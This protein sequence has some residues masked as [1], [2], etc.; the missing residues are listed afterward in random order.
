MR[1]CLTMLL[2]AV[3]ASVALGQNPEKAFGVVGRGLNQQPAFM[4]RLSVDRKDLTYT[5]GE[6]LVVTV[7]S[8][9][10]G[11]L[12][13][14]YIQVEN[15]KEQIYVLYPNEFDAGKEIPAK[16][17][18]AIPTAKDSWDLKCIPPFG[19]GR[20]F[21]LVS[22][23]PLKAAK[24]IAAKDGPAVVLQ[25][26]VLGLAREAQ[27][28][29]PQEFA[30]VYLD[31]T[32]LAARNADQ[33][34][35]NNKPR[36]VAVCI[37][38]SDYADERINDLTISH[39]DAEVMAQMLKDHCR[40]E[41]IVLLTNE[42]AT[43]SAIEAAIFKD[44][45]SKT[46]PG[47]TVFIFYSGHGGR[48][49]DT[50]G[51]EEDGFDEYL[52]PQDGK[53]GADETMILDDVFGRWMQQLEGRKVCIILDNCHSG[54]AAKGLKKGKFPKG[55]GLPAVEKQVEKT[56]RVDFFD[57]ELRR[58]KDLGQKDT[59]VV[60]ACQANQ[61]AWE[62]LPPNKESVLTHYLVQ[63]ANNAN[64]R[65]KVEDVFRSIEEDIKKYVHDNMSAEQTPLL[66]NNA[67][68]SVLLIP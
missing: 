2:V 22:K 56:L 59:V 53:L 41:D 28:L 13:L 54:G 57:G 64:G 30:E 65:L 24:A 62:M 9:R 16:T 1:S 55:I 66:I 48:C 17:E 35:L 5:E 47:D 39:H 36:R 63:A 3:L 29:K 44:L 40:V 12:Y 58:A 46:K 15:G 6:N 14:Y 50:N 49:A 32:T 18:V 45:P 61:L 34:D 27:Q 51:D 33:R 10:K 68:E 31:L 8:E 52:V 42:A 43:R 37:G 26:E 67:S 60:A 21:A 38:I 7:E 20:L 11:F 23:S 19:K 4:V 25:S